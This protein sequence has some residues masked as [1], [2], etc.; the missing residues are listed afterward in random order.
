M[1][2]PALS[3]TLGFDGDMHRKVSDNIKISKIY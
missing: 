3:P 2:A 1:S